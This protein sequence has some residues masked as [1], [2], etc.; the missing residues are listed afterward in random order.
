MSKIDVS[1]PGQ[2]KKSKKK[3]KNKDENAVPVN[4]NAFL[5][6]LFSF[7][8]VSSQKSEIKTVQRD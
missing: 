6:L 5:D 1:V 3:K 2:K 7:V 8:G 4:R